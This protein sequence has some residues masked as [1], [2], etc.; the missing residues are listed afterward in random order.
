MRLR[1]SLRA[2]K[3]VAAVAAVSLALAAPAVVHAGKPDILQLTPSSIEVT[4]TPIRSF[5]GGNGTRFGKLDWRGGLTLTSGSSF[6]GGFSGLLVLDNGRSLVTVSDAGFWLTAG[7]DYADGKLS[8]VE[9]AKVGQIRALK[10][11][12]LE[13]RRDRDA[14]SLGLVSEAA[15]AAKLLIGFENNARVGRF[16]LGPEGLSPPS[17]YLDLPKAMQALRGNTGI[18]SIALIGAGPLAGSYVSFAERKSDETGK[19]IGWV[20]SG[21]ESRTIRLEPIGNFD[22]SDIAAMP[23]GG[24]LVLERRFRWS[25]GIS[26]RIRRLSSKALRADQPMLGE[27]LFEAGSG[28]ALDNME[29]M[30]VH[31]SQSG[32]TIV[33]LISD[34]NFSFFQST[35]LLQFALIE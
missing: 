22:V 5:D 4:A 23:D 8:G 21:K 16:E 6:F 9:A 31:R 14:E 27:I 2:S 29:G 3:N 11:K 19:R 25:E 28:T 35:V 30:A 18:E 17:A 33:T 7:I 34:D 20:F 15:G 1:L 10:G 24:L 32:E 13:R 26:I 12:R